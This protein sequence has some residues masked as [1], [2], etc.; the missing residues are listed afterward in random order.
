[1]ENKSFVNM[2]FAQTL[3]EN[4]QEMNCSKNFGIIISIFSIVF[5]SQSK[6][7]VIWYEKYGTNQNKTFFLPQNHTKLDVNPSKGTL[8]GNSCIH[9]LKENSLNINTE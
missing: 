3:F 4:D 7:F 8:F 1:M 6:Y 2:T 5:V 9:M